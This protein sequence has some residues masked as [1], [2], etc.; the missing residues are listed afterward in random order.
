MA[1]SSTSTHRG[2]SVKVEGLKELSRDLKA[3]GD[4]EGSNA[5]KKALAEAADQVVQAAQANAST[6]Q[7]RATAGRLKASKA[8]ASSSVTLGGKPYDL[9]V[10][11]GSKRWP[12]FPAWRGNGMDAGYLLFPA[13][14]EEQDRIVEP[15]AD[16]IDALLRGKGAASLGAAGDLMAELGRLTGG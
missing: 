3:A 14:R 12:Q 5:L 6:R 16:A 8:A 13:I 2:F 7:Q 15:V 1:R 10:E 9:G 4:F 11:F